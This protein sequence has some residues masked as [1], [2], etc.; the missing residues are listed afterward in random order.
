MRPFS[1]KEYCEGNQ[2]NFFVISKTS[3]YSGWNWNKCK[4]YIYKDWLPYEGM[5]LHHQA[6]ALVFST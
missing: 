5:L 6:W 1:V 4:K 3:L 2:K